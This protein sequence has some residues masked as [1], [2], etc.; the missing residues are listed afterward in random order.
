MAHFARIDENNIVQEVLVVNNDVITINGVESEQAGIDFLVELFGTTGW[1]Q[2]SY[3]NKF[4]KNFPGIGM[5][6]NKAKDAFIAHQPYKDWILDEETCTWKP[7]FDY[8]NDGN[9]YQWMPEEHR[10]I[11]TNEPE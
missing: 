9:E 4:R 7:P 10:W 6:Y 3:N 1:L 11:Q 2:C 5:T 8:P